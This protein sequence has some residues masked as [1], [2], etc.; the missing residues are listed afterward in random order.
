MQAPAL[1][2]EVEKEFGVPGAV[3]VAL[4]GLETD[5]GTQPRQA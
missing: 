5:F 4:W 3:I 2:L 1:A